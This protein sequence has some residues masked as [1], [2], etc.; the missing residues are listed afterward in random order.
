MDGSKWRCPSFAVKNSI[1]RRADLI[2]STAFCTI[3]QFLYNRNCLRT[4]TPTSITQTMNPLVGTPHIITTKEKCTG[5]LRVVLKAIRKKYA[6]Q[7]EE[8]KS[9]PP[10]T[11][12]APLRLKADFNC[13]DLKNDFLTRSRSARG[14]IS[15]SGK[16]VARWARASTSSARTANIAPAARL[17]RSP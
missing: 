4:A 8:C 16:P 11:Q 13:A 15:N 9:K 1:L 2:K 10:A 5:A 3:I 17:P 7:P 6:M 12:A 14:C